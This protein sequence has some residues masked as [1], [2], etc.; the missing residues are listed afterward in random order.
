[1]KRVAADEEESLADGQDIGGPDPFGGVGRILRD[2]EV[3]RAGAGGAR[4][5]P[6]SENGGSSGLAATGVVEAGKVTPGG[7]ESAEIV[8]PEGE[9][10]IESSAG[11]VADQIKARAGTIN[12]SELQGSS[13]GGD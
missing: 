9:R 7:C 10:V 8:D 11:N 2:T 1:M 4:Q 12:G 6:C 3:E 13:V 5:Q